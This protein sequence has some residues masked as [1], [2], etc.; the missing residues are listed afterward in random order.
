MFDCERLYAVDFITRVCVCSL[1]RVWFFATPWTVACQVPLTMECSRQE[2][3]SGFHF[4]LWEIFLT[5]GSNPPLLYLLHQQ[6]DFFFFFFY[7]CAAWV[8]RIS[9]A[10]WVPEDIKF[11][12]LPLSWLT[13]PCKHQIHPFVHQRSTECMFCA[14]HGLLLLL[15]PRLLGIPWLHHICRA[16]SPAKPDLRVGGPSFIFLTP[17]PTP[18]TDPS[19]EKGVTTIAPWRLWLSWGPFLG[20][21]SQAAPGVEAGVVGRE[22]EPRMSEALQSFLRTCGPSSDCPV[23]GRSIE[24]RC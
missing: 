16:C 2:C 11:S 12:V 22:E 17:H 3:W 4:L 10:Y 23:A 14:C 8:S 5:Q 18:S 19:L 6:A 9:V 21:V 24:A 7:H 15:N 13:T 1:R 20:S